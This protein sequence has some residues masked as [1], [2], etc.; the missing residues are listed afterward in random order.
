[1]RKASWYRPRGTVCALVVLCL[2]A[3]ASHGAVTADPAKVT[4]TSPGQSFTIKLANDGAPIPATD[5]RGWQFLAS[6]HD[7]KH[8]VDVEKMNGAIKLSPSNTVELGSYDL[9]ID[10]AQGSVVVRVLTPL[11]DVPDVVERMAALTG[12]SEQKIA[13]KLGLTSA[14]GRSEIQIDLPPVYYEGQTLEMTM[15]SKPVDGHTCV[16]F[17]NGDAVAEGP[18]QNA[19]TY[20]FLEPGDYVLTY[21][22]TANENGKPVVAARA[23]SYTR[24]V[25]LPVVMSE[26]AVN[27]T[28]T[29][30]PPTGYQNHAWSLDGK[31]VS[32]EAELEQKFLAPG[33]H[34]IECLASAPNTGPAKG[35]LRIRYKTTVNPA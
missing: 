23:K 31:L 27:T 30:V 32:E 21:I 9:N 26:V 3:A 14:T 20:T 13:E 7:Y 15:P 22:E 2:G 5:I 19:F 12:Q 8:M 25:P 11:S 10:T 18:D 1:M 6:G 35:F 29:Y 17:I 34:I 28:V 33:T 16:W 4:F 24:V